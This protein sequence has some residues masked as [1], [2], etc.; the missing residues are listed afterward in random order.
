MDLSS[1]AFQ[2]C[3]I[4]AIFR[5]FSQ[6]SHL[7]ANLDISP[8]STFQ[9]TVGLKI[10]D[11]PLQNKN[12]AVYCTTDEEENIFLEYFNYVLESLNLQR[13]PNW[14]KALIN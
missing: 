2:C 1:L 8:F 13:P 5:K 12:L 4:F 3:A 10:S 9:R 6:F 7:R 11:V 14:R